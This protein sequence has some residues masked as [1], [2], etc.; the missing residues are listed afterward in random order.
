MSGENPPYGADINFWLEAP[1]SD[2]ELTF[3]GADGTIRTLKTNGQ[4]GLNRVWWDLRYEPGLSIQMQTPPL[5]SK[6]LNVEQ[7]GK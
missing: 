1:A 4:A 2:V 7:S 6:S 5:A 3:T